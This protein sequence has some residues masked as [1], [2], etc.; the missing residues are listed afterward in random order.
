MHFLITGHTGFKGSWLL[1]LLRTLGHEV[2]G[3]AL[4]PLA[5]SL[6]DRA[7]LSKELTYDF[8]ADIRDSERLEVL[9]R[10]ISPDVVIHLAAQP[11]VRE[12]YRDPKLTFET[13]VMGTLN[14]LQT[15]QKLKGLKAR[16]I[17]TTDKVY[18]N[19]NLGL[20][21][22]ESDPLG[23]HDPYSSSKAMADL[24]TQ[25]WVTSFGGPTTAIAR[26]GNVVGGGDVSPERLIPDLVRAFRNGHPA[27]IRNP[28]AVRPWQHV[29]DCLNGYLKLVEQ[30]VAV[31]HMDQ[32]WNFGPDPSSARTVEE[33]ISVA[34]AAW[35]PSATWRLVGDDGLPEAHLLTLDSTKAEKELH[36]SNQL[37]FHLVLKW[38]IDW[39]KSVD[40][41]ATARDATVRQI[42]E[43]L[44]LDGNKPSLSLE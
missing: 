39:E 24:M 40:A 1:A 5:G 34:C 37:P 15:T 19:N 2:S 25:S 44:K 20:R 7:S 43:F 29:L 12:S 36:W 35:G 33:V 13:N 31:K 32:T 21:F 30:M 14:V 28:G 26:A 16:L 10:D 22:R 11:L 9:I 6:Y 17:I 3:I 23:G 4:D 8:R 38:T 42:E 27:E 18:K 41:G